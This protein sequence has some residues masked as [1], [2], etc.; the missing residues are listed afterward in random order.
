MLKV[1]NRPCTRDLA[2]KNFKAAKT[3][4][5]IAIL[6]IALITLLFASLFIVGLSF[7]EVFQQANFR[8]AGGY[9]RSWRLEI[10]DRRAVP[11]VVGVPT[12]RG[13]GSKSCSGLCPE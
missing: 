1:S 2:G 9:A 4:N 5:L 10:S 11:G 13:L 6:L 3:R 8:Q 12:D 7:N